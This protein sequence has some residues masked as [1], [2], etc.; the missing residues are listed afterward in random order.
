MRVM[1]LW[2]EDDD[3]QHCLDFLLHHRTAKQGEVSLTVGF[4]RWLF[5]NNKNQCQTFVVHSTTDI[6]G[7]YE[8]IVANPT[9]TWQINPLPP[10]PVC[11]FSPCKVRDHD[12]SPLTLKSHFDAL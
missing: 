5:G 1:F 9:D 6:A 7:L 12:H 3:T 10:P 2:N 4:R 11:P 8:H